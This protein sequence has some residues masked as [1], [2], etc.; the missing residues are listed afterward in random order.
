[1]R[2]EEY[3]E[4]LEPFDSFV[5]LEIKNLSVIKWLRFIILFLLGIIKEQISDSY[6]GCFDLIKPSP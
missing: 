2:K 3:K 6:M 4:N 1:M 5:S